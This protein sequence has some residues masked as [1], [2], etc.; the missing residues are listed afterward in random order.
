MTEL[1]IAEELTSWKVAF[2]DTMALFAQGTDKQTLKD[3]SERYSHLKTRA[4]A[5]SKELK[6]AESRGKL[7][8]QEKDLL[9]PAIKDVAIFC[10]ARIG[11][12]NKQDLSSS[13]Y[14][15]KDYLAYYLSEMDITE[16]SN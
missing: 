12:M 10:N 4:L 11:S 13:L 8:E 6:K 16:T 15:C 3:I 7:T 1:E 2:S 14:D 9:A 5:R